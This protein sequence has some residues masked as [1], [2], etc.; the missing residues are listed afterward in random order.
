[1]WAVRN[2]ET[3]RVY[4]LFENIAQV[5]L[6]DNL[7]APGLHVLD[8][9]RAEYEIVETTAPMVFVGGGVLTF[10]TAW[11]VHGQE[12]YDAALV[13]LQSDLE[14]Q[15]IASLWQAAHDLEF[16]SISGSAIGLITMGVLTGKPKAIA[17]QAWIKGIWELYYQRK[18]VNSTDCDYSSV[19]P[20]PHSVPE[21]MTELG[22]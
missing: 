17:V 4:Y 14:R 12:A 18:D 21:L 2:K 19:G 5:Q 11:G 7:V 6:E 10:D 8:M 1:M 20:C 22:M 9:N 15:R 16:A 3:K 13:L